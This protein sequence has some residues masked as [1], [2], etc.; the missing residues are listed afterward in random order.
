MYRAWAWHVKIPNT[1]GLWCMQGEWKAD[2]RHGYG[3]CFFA[4]Q[5]LLPITTL[6]KSFIPTVVCPDFARKFVSAN[7]ILVCMIVVERVE[8]KFEP[9]RPFIRSFETK[10]KVSRVHSSV[11][12]TTRFSWWIECPPQLIFRRA[13]TFY[14]RNLAC[15]CEFCF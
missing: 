8:V 1:C 3:V 4:V 11:R 5:P 7:V 13:K 12:T 15:A 9:I 14:H 2:K 10:Q 6:H